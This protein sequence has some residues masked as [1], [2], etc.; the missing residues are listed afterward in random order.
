MRR[1]IPLALIAAP[2]ILGLIFWPIVGVLLVHIRNDL[3]RFFFNLLMT[4]H[5]LGVVG[6]VLFMLFSDD[7]EEWEILVRIG[8]GQTLILC[9]PYLTGQ[10]AIWL[11]YW[12]GCKERNR[13]QV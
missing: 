4:F 7:T 1:I 12:T 2:V 10:A 6:V 5:Y 8:L 11:A 9:V 3:S 13:V